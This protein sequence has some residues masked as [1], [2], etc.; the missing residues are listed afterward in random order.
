MP[1]C[2]SH[3]YGNCNSYGDSHSN[4]HSNCHI[5]A[6]TYTNAYTTGADHASRACYKVHGLQTV[7]LF[8]SGL[9]SGAVEIYRNGV[10]IVTVPPKVVSIPIT[11]TAMA[12]EPIPIGCAKRVLG[13]ALIRSL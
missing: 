2:K 9:S 7:D 4:S 13:T 3:T 8:W 5:H 6:Y 11:S 12:G 10:L 1:D